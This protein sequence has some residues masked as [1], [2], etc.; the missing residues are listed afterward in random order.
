[1]ELDFVSARG[2]VLPLAVNKYFYLVNA[3]GQTQA[4]TSISSVLIG[5]VDGDIPNNVQAQPRSII[6]TLRINPSE[7]VE[8]A[9]REI[10]KAVKLKQGGALIWTQNDRT[11]KIDGIVESIE[12]P[13]W[14]KSVAMQIT[15]HCG[16]PFWEDIDFVV[17]Q[18]NE[19]INLHYFTAYE[20]DM[21]YFTEQGSP[22]GEYD[23][24][25]T[26]TFYN[27]GDV[28]VGMIIEIVAYNT[29]TNPIIYDLEGNFFGIG[30][31]TD[32]KKVVLN[33]GDTVRIN[34]IKGEK[35]AVLNGNTNLLDKIKPQSTWLQ[36][37]TGENMFSINSDDESTNNMS[38]NLIYKRRYI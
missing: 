36:M 33:A 24:I 13:R 19:A 30:Y 6:L 16:Q 11:V 32:N 7:N 5:G 4:D 12:M 18:I 34:T 3:S 1:M 29:V 21:L 20:G 14:N 23:T 8:E 10:M 35:S 31:G 2:N 27:T 28:D 25:R 37:F 17:Q 22:F 15:L 26:K 38:F 9:K